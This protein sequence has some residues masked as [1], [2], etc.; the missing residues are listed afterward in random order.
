MAR[1][2]RH[3]TANLIIDAAASGSGVKGA[4]ASAY[5]ILHKV[6]MLHTSGE[7]EEGTESLGREAHGKSSEVTPEEGSSPPNTPPQDPH[8]RLR[9]MALG[10]ERI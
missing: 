2:N 5:R 6:G 3:L 1:G 8:H 7:A 9:L 4:R 10:S